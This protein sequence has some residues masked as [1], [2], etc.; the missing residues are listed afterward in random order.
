LK[1][2][3]IYQ[4]PTFLVPP[5]SFEN[6]TRGIVACIYPPQLHIVVFLLMSFLND[7][8]MYYDLVMIYLKLFITVELSLFEKKLGNTL[9]LGAIT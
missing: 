9:Y 4:T 7:L 5:S 8:S 2:D 1:E 3:R 6:S